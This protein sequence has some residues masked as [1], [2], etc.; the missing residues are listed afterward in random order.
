M[1]VDYYAGNWQCL[2]TPIMGKS[3][4]SSCTVIS[5]AVIATGPDFMCD[6]LGK[7]SQGV[8]S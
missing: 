8:R 7:H 1:R 3:F 2:G 4:S 5:D 6:S